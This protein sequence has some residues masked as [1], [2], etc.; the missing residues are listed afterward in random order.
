MKTTFTTQHNAAS[1]LQGSH[2]A[3]NVYSPLRRLTL[4]VTLLMAF[5]LGA[6]AQNYYVFRN[7]N[8]YYIYNNN[9]SVGATDTFSPACV[10]IASG[11]LGGTSRSLQSYVDNSDY[12]RGSASSL[13]IGDSQ[14]NWRTGGSN[15]NN[16]LRYYGSSSSNRRYIGYQNSAFTFNS[17]IST[18][19]DFVV[20]PV[21]F[22][23]VATTSTPPTINGN[24]VLTASGNYAYTA[25]DAT[26]Q[27]GGYTKY[28]FNSEDYY[29]DSNNNSITPQAATLSTP[30]WSISTNE[31]A[32][33]NSSTGVVTVNRIP[34]S[35]VTLIITATVDVTGGTPAAPAGT[36]L[37]GT[38]EIT[39]QGS[40]PAAPTISVSGTTVTLQTDATGTTSIRYTI[41][42]TNPT[43]TTGTVYNGAFD[44][45]GSTNSPVTIKAITVRNGNASSV[46]TQQVKL[47]LPEPVITVNA[48]TG[49]ATITCSNSS[50][51]IYY[52]TDDSAP[53][54]TNGTS[55]N[56]QITGLATMATVKA[57]AICDGG[58]ARQ[59][60]RPR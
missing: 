44:I 50:A 19:R 35:D 32:T 17:N 29:F 41:D 31:Y 27:V 37:V 16:Y 7:S 3:H 45:S 22:S 55:Y 6:R 18:S 59:W 51:T 5:A 57:I 43:A 53:S 11:S 2:A 14:T 10:W 48:A 24:D 49:T 9:G 52:T 25:T 26:Y 13:S 36:T 39:I 12:L 28:S 40:V 1:T 47:T 54:A 30:I 42:G 15:G 38:K 56:G 4:L 34:T 8:G 21:T 20:Y 58:T 23:T 46:T 33:I 60:H